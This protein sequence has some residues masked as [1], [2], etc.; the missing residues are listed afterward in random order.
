MGLLMSAFV[1]GEA[2]ARDVDLG[3]HPLVYS[4]PLSKI[5]CENVNT[6]IRTLNEKKCAPGATP[7]TTLDLY[8]ELEVG[9]PDSLRT[10]F[11]NSLK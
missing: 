7:V 8:R 9:T 11:V 2:A 1:A 5:D 4:T 6:A 3:I 10:C